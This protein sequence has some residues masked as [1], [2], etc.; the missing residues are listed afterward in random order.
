MVEK[1]RPK[2]GLALLK[3]RS[4][5]EPFK[6][7]FSLSPCPPPDG[8]KIYDLCVRSRPSFKAIMNYISRDIIT[9]E[10]WTNAPWF[11][12]YRLFSPSSSDFSC[13]IPPEMEK[14]SVLQNAGHD[15]MLI[16]VIVDR[17]ETTPLW[18]KLFSP[19]ELA[20]APGTGA[21]SLLCLCLA[22]FQ[23][24]SD[25]PRARADGEEKQINWAVLCPPFMARTCHFIWIANMLYPPMYSLGFKQGFVKIFYLKMGTLTG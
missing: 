24:E 9:Q 17:L 1:S 18:R 14:E 7:D 16:K 6:S 25:I 23:Q 19:Y 4:T 10:S 11:K 13:C 5:A 21:G 3:R 2:Y 20:L 8:S 12:F 22:W 15:V